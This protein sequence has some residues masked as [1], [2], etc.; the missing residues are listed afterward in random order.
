MWSAYAHFLVHMFSDSSQFG[1]EHSLSLFG[2][3]GHMLPS[4][5]ESLQ[6]P[7]ETQRDGI[8]Q[9]AYLE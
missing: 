8:R 4:C 7:M 3:A 1:H 2:A 9:L 5:D 6:V